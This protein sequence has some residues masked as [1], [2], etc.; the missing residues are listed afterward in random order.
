MTGLYWKFHIKTPILRY[1]KPTM[2]ILD[3]HL[4]L[5]IDLDKK[6]GVNQ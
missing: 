2:T 1:I 3:G 6:L 5:V 4:E